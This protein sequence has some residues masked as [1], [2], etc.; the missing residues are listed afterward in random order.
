MHTDSYRMTHR[1]SICMWSRT[2]LSLDDC[3]QLKLRLW[4]IR[5]GCVWCVRA[6]NRETIVR[7]GC[8]RCRFNCV[9][10]V[11]AS[12]HNDI[13]IQFVNKTCVSRLC[14]RE[15]KWRQKC[16]TKLCERSKEKIKNKR[17]KKKK[18]K[19]NERNVVYSINEN[20]LCD[21]CVGPVC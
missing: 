7:F 15:L 1:G 14:V 6:R 21:P 18:K 10:A 11:M 4:T 13:G 16:T 12:A 3:V 17:I 9:C 5:C 20:I 2:L 8:H 19:A